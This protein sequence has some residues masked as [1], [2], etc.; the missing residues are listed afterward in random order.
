MQ[1]R[2]S[3]AVACCPVCG[4]A[5]RRVHS[6][7]LRRLGDLPWEGISVSILLQTRKFFC[8]GEN[9]RRCIF[10]EPLA[11]TVLRYA[12]RTVR[13]A[14]ALDW[15]TLVVGGQA[16][17]RLAR[18]L[19]LLVSG[20]TLLRQLR[21]AQR[22]PVAVPRVLG[23]DDWAW[24]KGHRYGTILCDLE[25]RR[26]IDLLPD[27]EAGTVAAWLRQHPGSEIVSRDR[28]GIYAQAARQAAPN[29][30]QVADRWHL[31]R[32]LSEALKNALSPHHRLLAHAV[33][34]ATDE[35][36]IVDI[37]P[38]LSVPLWE[39][40]AQQKNRA[41][42]FSR[43]EEVQRLGKTG[44]SHA[45]IGRQLGL[46]HRTVRKFLRAET[47]PEA[48]RSLRPGIV[49]PYADYLDQR[50]EQ[51]CRNVSRLWRELREQGFTGQINIVRRWLRC[52]RG[53]HPTS[54]NAVPRKAPPRI[55]V[56]QTVWHIL[57]ETPAAQSYLE[58]VYQASPEILTLAQL[59]KGFFR[60]VRDRDLTALPPW[61][62]SAK[63]TALAAF[64]N[65]LARDRKAVEAALTLPWSQ[66]PRRRA[67]SPAQTDQAADVR[68]RR[69]R[70]AQTQS[71]PKG[72]NNKPL[73][74]IEEPSSHFTKCTEEPFL[75]GAYTTCWC[76]AITSLLLQSGLVIIKRRTR[77]AV[78]N[79]GI[80]GLCRFPRAVGRVGQFHRSTL[81]IRPSFPPRVPPRFS[82]CNSA[83][84]ADE[85]SSC[86]R[87]SRCWS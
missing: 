33:R 14:E 7:Y 78:R 83:R 42:R 16:G 64:A 63:A 84:K 47:F 52:R 70:P 4:T 12:R 29:A 11:G 21:R 75:S 77:R 37:T 36:S 34:N 79:V 49:D 61:F 24:R 26:V 74:P 86:S 8:V 2:T 58:Q 66:R 13:S 51:G 87:S 43:Y 65:H 19:G 54:A 40:R 5:S 71:A 31:L 60:I 76:K 69:L 35:V 56:R 15:I 45:A 68:P 27:R 59:A 57:K 30:V 55:S 18:R 22:A 85:G 23:I 53:Y 73:K 50:L 80:D 20:S 6:R 44:A 62:E 48:Q 82:L 72:L 1:L 38:Q 10:T 3:R 41:R 39:L 25:S 28:G 9:C 46:D 17:A 67:G 81:S 32:N